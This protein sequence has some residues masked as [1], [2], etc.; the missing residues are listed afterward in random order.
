MSKTE[1]VTKLKTIEPKIGFQF[2]ANGKDYIIEDKLSIA[3]SMLSSEFEINLFDSSTN[4]IKKTLISAYND[5][6]GTNKDRSV[7]FADAAIKIH[8]LVNKIQNNLSFKDLPILRYCAL[9]INHKDEDRRTI[10]DEQINTKIEDWQEEG[11]EISGFFLLVLSVLPSVKKDF[12]KYM[13]AFS[14]N[15]VQEKK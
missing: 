10:T 4:S 14:K 3:R 11:I 12:V 9:Y 2:S 15:Q 6:N 1:S 13:E 7:K 5:L 8:N